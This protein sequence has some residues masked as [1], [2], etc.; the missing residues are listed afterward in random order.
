MENSKSL[1]KYLFRYFWVLAVVFAISL[2]ISNIIFDEYYKSKIVKNFCL[3][4]YNTT[5]ESLDQWG[6]L[7]EELYFL[8]RDEL[9]Q[10]L[11]EMYSFLKKSS[12]TDQEISQKLHSLLKNRKDKVNWYI[13]NQSGIIERTD[14][15][16]DLG[17]DI[18]EKKITG[19]SFLG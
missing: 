4:V 9:S 3:S 13:I 2:S 12:P 19:R 6:E 10:I 14:Y 15:A 17:I 1:T 7:F 16:T 5:M 18:S 8:T 11:D